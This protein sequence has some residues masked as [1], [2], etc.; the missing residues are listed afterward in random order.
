MSTTAS[1]EHTKYKRT[2]LLYIVQV[3]PTFQSG[4]KRT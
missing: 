1:A 3:R 2:R 4:N